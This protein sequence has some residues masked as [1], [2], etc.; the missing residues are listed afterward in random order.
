ME[1]V[2]LLIYCWI[3]SICSQYALPEVSAI[4]LAMLLSHSF[5]ILVCEWRINVFLKLLNVIQVLNI[6]LM[7]VFLQVFFVIENV[8]CYSSQPDKKE[9]SMN[10]F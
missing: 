2:G 1:E 5:E 6:E 10:I 3:V 8:C 4:L 9:Y 7:L